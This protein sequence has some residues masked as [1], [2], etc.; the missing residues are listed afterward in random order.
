MIN[1]VESKSNNVVFEN[2]SKPNVSFIKSNDIKNDSFE[3][4]K[5]TDDKQTKKTSYLKPALIAVG[6]AVLGAGAFILGKGKSSSIKISAEQINQLNEMV[7][8]G[9]VKQETVDLMLK[10]LKDG[11]LTPQKLYKSIC[12]YM[13]IK[14]AP[15]LNIVDIN[16][17]AMGVYNPNKG[18]IS[19]PENTSIGTMFHELTHFQQFQKV[20]RAFGKD[21]MIDAQVEKM[22]TR[23]KTNPKYAEYKLGKPFDK[24]SAEEIGGLLEKEKARLNS[25]FNEDFYKKVAE[26]NGEL[27]QKEFE[28][29]KLYLDAIKCPDHNSTIIE[30]EAYH[31]EIVFENEVSKIN[32]VLRPKKR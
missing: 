18:N 16:Q 14:K 3:L 32:K 13:N 23:L 25:E 9:E 26:A 27:S 12:E 8:K 31:N 21:A 20:Y 22:H 7:N 6:V 29:A 17:G 5:K 1:S 4:S 11:K 2:F 19:F 10:L 24:A 15:E 28:E 30:R